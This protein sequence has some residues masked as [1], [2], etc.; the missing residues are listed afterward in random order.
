M[1]L[2]VHHECLKIQLFSNQEISK[3]RA[4]ADWY[5]F[6]LPFSSCAENCSHVSKEGIN[7]T[8][9][10]TSPSD[11]TLKSVGCRSGFELNQQ[12]TISDVT[13]HLNGTWTTFPD[14]DS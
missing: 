4:I 3:Q 1:L 11:F 7:V 9:P 12:S 13:C 10:Q 8:V 6:V 5:D 2:E 14:C